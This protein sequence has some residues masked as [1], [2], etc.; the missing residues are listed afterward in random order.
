MTSALP[1]PKGDGKIGG[2]ALTGAALGAGAGFLV[3]GPAGALVGG[4]GGGVLGTAEGFMNSYHPANARQPIGIDPAGSYTS[5]G[6][7]GHRAERVI[8]V[9]PPQP[10]QVE[11]KVDGHSLASVI[12]DI[13]GKAQEFPTQAPAEDGTGRFSAGDHNTGD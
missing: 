11:L 2:G 10:A 12:L 5:P 1:G 13:M 4:I 9:P 8:V 6:K 7:T 3:G